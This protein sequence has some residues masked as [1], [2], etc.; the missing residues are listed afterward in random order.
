MK[1]RIAYALGALALAAK[2]IAFGVGWGDQVHITGLYVLDNGN[3]FLTTSANQ[4][5]DGC[6]GGAVPQYLAI[7]ASTPNFKLL[8]ATALLAQQT[9]STVTLRYN[10]CL[11]GSSWPLINSVAVPKIF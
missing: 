11:G 6:H 2:P 9:G 10:G 1:K 4:N 3:A 7:D 8:Y 5:P